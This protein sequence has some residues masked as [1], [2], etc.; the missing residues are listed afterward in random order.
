MLAASEA[1]DKSA[2]DQYIASLSAA[3]ARGSDLTE[4]QVKAM[5][6]SDSD[7][8]ELVSAGAALDDSDDA[9]AMSAKEPVSPGENVDFSEV[10]RGGYLG[11]MGRATVHAAGACAWDGDM[12]CQTGGYAHFTDSST[13]SMHGQGVM[14]LEWWCAWLG[15]VWGCDS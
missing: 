3:A 11:G 7:P 1:L 15:A 12:M 5:F 13:V 4:E 2:V 14:G 10:G 8:L 6:T 9:A